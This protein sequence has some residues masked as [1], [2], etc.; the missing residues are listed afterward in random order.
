[1]INYIVD[2]NLPASRF[3]NFTSRYSNSTVVYYV[4]NNNKKI[5]FKTYVKASY[6]V[7][8][9]D[10][11]MLIPSQYEYRPDL[12]SLKVYG[13]TDYW[14]ALMEANNINDVFNFKTGLTIRIPSQP[15]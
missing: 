5:A 9:N 8:P 10:R 13:T 4:I 11:F 14:W 6:P 3:V 7:G 1:M 15:F 12:A 2:S